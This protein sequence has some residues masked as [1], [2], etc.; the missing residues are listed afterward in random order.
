MRSPD[1]TAGSGTADA[2]PA[3]ASVPAP[4]IEA[5]SV[6]RV[7]RDGERCL[8]GGTLDFET[9]REALEKVAPMIERGEVSR[10]DLGGVT[11]SNSAGLALV[12]E[13]LATARRAGHPL[14]LE[15]VPEG[16]RQLAAVC[17]VDDLI[18]VPG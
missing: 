5:E 10:I 7:E 12:I 15:R 2:S 11:R 16:L 6:C 14:A 18:A 3:L 1:G 4:G 9:A 17:R 8:V 13:W